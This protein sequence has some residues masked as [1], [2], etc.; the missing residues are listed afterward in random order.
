[1][2]KHIYKVQSV[3]NIRRR[4]V[5]YWLTSYLKMTLNGLKMS[6]W[7]QCLFYASILL[8]SFTWLL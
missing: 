3:D 5:V 1:V 2:G 7:C 6:F 4:E 8:D